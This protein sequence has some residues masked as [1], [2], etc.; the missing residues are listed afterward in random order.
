ML[1][2]WDEQSST[3]IL[4][5]GR[6]ERWNIRK[7]A[8]DETNLVW[9]DLCRLWFEDVQCL[10]D[11]AL[12]YLSLLDKRSWRYDRH[13]SGHKVVHSPADFTR[14]CVKDLGQPIH[15]CF[16]QVRS[17]EISSNRLGVF[18][19]VIYCSDSEVTDRLWSVAT[20]QKLKFRLELRYYFVNFLFFQF[21]CFEFRKVD[22]WFL[23]GYYWSVFVS[24]F[25]S[26]AFVCFVVVAKFFLQIV[27]GIKILRYH[28]AAMF[29]VCWTV[30][31][32]EEFS[33]VRRRQV[34]TL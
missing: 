24:V 13:I 15:R 7:V 31:S 34:P 29:I 27:K 2:W 25:L 33:L 20:K 1:L 14:S 22:F 8:N 16:F 11:L 32:W 30:A 12:D 3:H 10:C 23:A 17:D 21:N 5:F 28:R 6:L 4:A 18:Q 26:V 19:L 9:C